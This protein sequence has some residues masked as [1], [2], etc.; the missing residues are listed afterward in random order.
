MAFQLDGGEEVGCGLGGL[1]GVAKCLATVDC[2]TGIRYCSS[3]PATFCAVSA[4]LTCADLFNFCI[5]ASTCFETS[6]EIYLDC[7]DLSGTWGFLTYEGLCA[8]GLFCCHSLNS[9][10]CSR[11]SFSYS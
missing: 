2:T 10:H 9:Q 5:L 7:M 6:V 4:V 11:I 8:S 3:F 1:G